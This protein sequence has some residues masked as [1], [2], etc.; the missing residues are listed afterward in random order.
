MENG[1]IGVRS[2][3]VA[4]HVVEVQE[5]V[6]ELAPTPPHNMEENLVQELVR[7]Q[8]NAIQGL[9]Q[10]FFQQ[11]TCPETHLGFCQTSKRETKPLTVI[12]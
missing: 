5:Q 8:R 9:V 6:N 10:V 12:A 1:V 3:S 2:V 11:A 7:A 4:N